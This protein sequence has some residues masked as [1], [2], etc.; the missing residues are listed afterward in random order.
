[1]K[2]LEWI[3]VTCILAISIGCIAM[4]HRAEQKRLA[5]DCKQCKCCQGCEDCKT[6]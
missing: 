5:C 1:M 6:K 2:T 3:I 4:G